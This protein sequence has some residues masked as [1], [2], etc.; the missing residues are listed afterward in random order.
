MDVI[1]MNKELRTKGHLEG[2]LPEAAYTQLEV[3][4]D[5]GEERGGVSRPAPQAARSAADSEA[6]V[7]P[8]SGITG[9]L[10]AYSTAMPGE[11]L[12]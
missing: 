11:Q 1:L 10:R 6:A 12:L 8:C 5:G 9:L 4:A 7:G 2:G 3:A